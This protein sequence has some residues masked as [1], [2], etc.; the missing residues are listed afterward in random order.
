MSRGGNT[1]TPDWACGSTSA[2]SRS[3]V[4]WT[5]IRAHVI[6]SMATNMA[7]TAMIA[8]TGCS[9]WGSG[10]P[11][12]SSR[13]QACPIRIR[14][15][16]S[17]PVRNRNRLVAG[18]CHVLNQDRTARPAAPH[19]HVAAYCNDTPEHVF[20]VAGDRDFLHGMANFAA[21][22]PVARR[23]A[24]V[25]ARHKVHALTHELGD[26]K[27][28]LE[29]LQHAGEVRSLGAHHEVVV[30]ARIA[31]GF[32]AELARRIAAEEIAF[33][34]AVAHD[35]AAARRNAL[36]VERRAGH[37]LLLVRALVDAH[38]RREHLSSEAVDEERG[39]AV[40]VAAVH[41]R[42]EMADQLQRRRRLEHPRRL[43]GRNLA[44]A[45]ARHRAR[46]GVAPQRLRLG[47]LRARAGGAEPVVALHQA[48]VLGDHRA[49][50]P[51]PRAGIAAD[52]AEAVCE[53]ELRLVSGDGR[54]FRVADF[55]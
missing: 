41:G 32:Q 33:D 3:P 21:L 7:I 23:A 1:G 27:P 13:V 14:P 40:Q 53:D 22:D 30:T 15:P 54:T 31:G 16:G 6:N 12:R 47:E 36:L 2:S 52:E 11:P 43:A 19:E 29:F 26:E 45:E 8:V 28:A 38:Q 51:V 46:A 42:D 4:P 48:L 37:P 25:I 9:G 39:L 10:A 35:S 34:D 55:L 18:D 50:D 24:R 49:R 44:R 17:P 5:S 20:Q